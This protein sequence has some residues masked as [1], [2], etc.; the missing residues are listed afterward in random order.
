MGLQPAAGGA[1][2]GGTELVRT[3]VCVRGGGGRKGRG[4]RGRSQLRLPVYEGSVG[5]AYQ[6]SEGSW[7]SVGI[8]TGIQQH[9]RTLH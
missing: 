2:F 1:H 9:T 3:R 4:G 6:E 7:R 5:L 8:H